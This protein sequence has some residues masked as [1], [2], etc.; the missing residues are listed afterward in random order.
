MDARF[1][2]EMHQGKHRMRIIPIIAY[3]NDAQW[4]DF[5]RF[6]LRGVHD[7]AASELHGLGK[8]PTNASSCQFNWCKTVNNNATN[9]ANGNR[10]QGDCV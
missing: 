10:L 8:I 5:A 7:I 3:A 6:N 2:R 4:S 9:S 1:G